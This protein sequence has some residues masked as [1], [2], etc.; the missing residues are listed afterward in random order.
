M[1]KSY[2]SVFKLKNNKLTDVGYTKYYDK[3]VSKFENK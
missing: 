2:S 1:D 3:L